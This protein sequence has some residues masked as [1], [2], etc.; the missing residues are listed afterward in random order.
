VSVDTIATP[1]IAGSGR[2]GT[3]WVQDVLAQA[4][5]YATVFEPL[6]P[7]AIPAMAAYAGRYLQADDQCDELESYLERV[8]TGRIRNAWITYRVRPD[9]LVLR[10]NQMTD[11]RTV[12]EWL[13]RWKKFARH[14]ARYR[15]DR[16][17]PVLVKFIR[18]NLMLP[19]LASHFNVRIGA[20]VRH[21]GA[22]VESKMRLRGGD[23][24]P[25]AV[26]ERYRSQSRLMANLPGAHEKLFREHLTPA[27]K[28]ALIWCIENKLLM[29]RA[30]DWGVVPV[31]YEDLLDASDENAWESIV[32]GLGLKNI[33]DT[34]T[35]RSASQQAS[36]L[37]AGKGYDSR[38]CGGWLS[39]LTSVQIDEI[40]QV[41]DAFEIDQY[42]M[43]SML[44]CRRRA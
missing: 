27:G 16:G 30:T 11:P 10:F 5:G 3:T 43:N 1:I 17:K 32:K 23:W 39:R 26:I 36:L 41:L 31:F 22:V 15:R 8:F 29:G 7:D 12:Y 25:E 18:A 38:H 34:V 37:T 35:R 44:P 2:S 42:S 20:V 33:P 4:N 13:M 28:H 40:Q 19:W 6:H 9:R 24:E 21:P 14:Y